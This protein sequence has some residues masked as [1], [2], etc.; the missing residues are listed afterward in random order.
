MSIVSNNSIS[1]TLHFNDLIGGIDTCSYGKTFPIKTLIKKDSLDFIE[2]GPVY[3]KSLFTSHQLKV[4][5]TFTDKTHLS[6]PSWVILVT[7]FLIFILVRIKTSYPKRLKQ[8]TDGL[9][10]LRYIN[11][12]NRESGII[13]YKGFIEFFLLFVINTSLIIYF[14][15]AFSTNSS[16]NLINFVVLLKIC[17]LVASLY[18]LKIFIFT[19]FGKIFQLEKEL[20]VYL[21]NIF[22]INEALGLTF[23][24]ILLLI[25]YSPFENKLWLFYIAFLIFVLFFIYRFIRG[26]SIITSSVKFSKFYLFLYLC[27]LEITPFVILVRIILDNID[28]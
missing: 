4:K 12:I 10:A 5:T 20:S 9:Y 27:T 23:L 24:P 21:T 7:V 17:L 15:Q 16:L 2:K 8:I 13:S 1:D 22:L 28:F 11:Q 6:Q 26:I 25:I 18:L 3:I 19:V 14:F